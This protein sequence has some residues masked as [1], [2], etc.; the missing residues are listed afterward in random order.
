MG[1]ILGLSLGAT[2]AYLYAGIYPLQDLSVP[3]RIALGSTC[4]CALGG[5]LAPDPNSQN[6]EVRRQG[7][8]RIVVLSACILAGVSIPIAMAFAPG[9]E[10]NARAYGLIGLTLGG[11]AG[12]FIPIEWNVEMPDAPA[13]PI[14]TREAVQEAQQRKVLRDKKSK[15]RATTP[16]DVAKGA[17]GC[18]LAIPFVFAFA[19]IML[20]TW[21]RLTHHSLPR[22]RVID[23]EHVSSHVDRDVLRIEVEASASNDGAIEAAKMEARS[24]KSKNPRLGA[25]GTF[26]TRE[27]NPKH[28]FLAI[29]Y[30]PGGDWSKAS[31]AV[32][33]SKWNYS[34]RNLSTDLP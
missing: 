16:E 30:A 7:L 27:D 2:G 5:T 4:V 10:D 34:V 12:C 6:Y 13:P 15:T 26:V 8:N 28:I 1:A 23:I 17:V 18:C 21:G 33:L 20:A 31:N 9:Y 14:L 19:C 32:P 25:V 29:D 11:L 3:I 22:Y 24:W